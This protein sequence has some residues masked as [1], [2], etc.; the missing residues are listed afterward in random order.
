MIDDNEPGTGLARNRFEAYLRENKPD[1]YR[2]YIEVKKEALKEGQDPLRRYR[3]VIA[4]HLGEEKAVEFW[5]R[6]VGL[7]LVLPED[8]DIEFLRRTLAEAGM[9][10]D[11]L[12]ELLDDKRKIAD[13]LCALHLEKLKNVS[14]DALYELTIKIGRGKGRKGKR[15]P[16]PPGR[17]FLDEIPED[18]ITIDVF[19]LGKK[20]G[21]EKYQREY[22]KDRE[23]AEKAIEQKIAESGPK[24]RAIYEYIRGYY[25][26]LGALEIPGVVTKT[27]DTGTGKEVEFPALHQKSGAK[28]IAAK[29]RTLI[30]DE[31][32]TGKTAQA[33]IAKNLI[34]RQEGRR[35]TAVVVLPNHLMKQW[36]T[37][38]GLW[39]VEKKTVAVITSETKDETLR[40]IEA[41]KPDFVLISY[42]MVFRKWNGGTIGDRLAPDY[43]ILDEVHNAKEATR[44]R[45][46]QIM[47][48]SRKAKYVTML[49]GTPVPNRISD[50]GV[51]ASILWNYE[52]EPDEFNRRYRKKARVVR[53]LIAPMMLR[54]RKHETFGANEC[55]R[56]VVT[57]GMTPRQK[58]E[59]ERLELNP[60]DLE[61][62]P[63]IIQLRK[64]ALDPGLAGIDQDSPKYRKLVDMLVEHRDKLAEN[65]DHTPAV[66][67][68]SELKEGVLD[69]LCSRIAASGFRVGRIDGDP[70]H[71]GKNRERILREFTEGRYDVI[72]ATLKTLGEG[73]D[74]L[75]IAHRAYFIDVPYT[76]AR[77]AQGIARL[78]R[79]GQKNPV[80]IYLLVAEDSIDE[81]LLNLIEQ[82]AMIGEFLID[83]RPLT[84]T[85]AKI[86]DEAERLVESG[87]DPL[88]KLYTFF[89]RTTNRNTAVIIPLLQD[90]HIGEYVARHYWDN[91]EG[92]FYGN[93]MN[94]IVKVIKGLEDG[95]TT[96]ENVLDVASGPCCLARAWKRPVVSLDANPFALKLGKEK[97]G[98]MAGQAVQAS[99]TNIP[100]MAH[101]FDLTVFSL[102]LLHSVAEEREGILREIN[103]V[104]RTNGVLILTMPSGDERYDKLAMALPM[105]GFKVLPEITG[106][107]LGLDKEFECV[108]ISAVKVGEPQAGSVPLDLLDY[109]PESRSESWEAEV[110]KTID[111]KVCD[112][113]E[114][115]SMGVEEA[116]RKSAKDIPS[117]IEELKRKYGGIKGVCES[118][119]K[120]ELDARG[121]EAMKVHRRG[122][123]DSYHLGRKGE[124]ARMGQDYKAFVSQHKPEAGGPGKKQVR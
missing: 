115:D 25:R 100:M 87:T 91:F 35:T 59:H 65:G 74:Q 82:K 26:E 62:L 19:E 96:F 73:V 5:L 109:C 44:L 63:L 9:D 121:L 10:L 33:I 90:S 83:G 67:F 84:P 11:A 78:D 112:K 8:G 43:L 27:I 106:T 113:F 110:S 50:L 124:L 56:H 49:S 40:K 55:T 41:E 6:A 107:A 20:Y 48:L 51:V 45:S 7:R 119:P 114:I 3:E 102:G 39:N 79:K 13:I 75:S 72:V 122:R 104:M 98:E 16:P 18:K 53:E 66:V 93:M 80:D 29:K 42:D 22:E 120:E 38:I 58:M 24:K 94:L 57:V 36:E 97:L 37:Q 116:G 69:A 88:R 71:S 77:L 4:K 47:A 76:E 105:L 14:D 118:C 2:H 1:G 15:P 28:F 30:A 17:T 103:R 86:I 21:I 85:E 61:A 92:S 54:R 123:P 70:E 95:G 81:I 31:M 99:F 111:R 32:G 89:G 46:R 12:V 60:D 117:A 101:S 52:F 64:C 34:D 68:S 108:I 23:A